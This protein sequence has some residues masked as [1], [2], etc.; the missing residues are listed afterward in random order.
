MACDLAPH[1]I[2]VNAIAP[3][4]VDTAMATMQ[5][6]THEHHQ[7]WFREIYLRWGRIPLR[8]AALPADIARAVA[9]FCCDDC[10]YVTGQTLMVDG[11]LSATF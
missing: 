2:L 7:E 6:G 8:R 11:G 3:G 9:F 1:G 5:D 4:F 10:A